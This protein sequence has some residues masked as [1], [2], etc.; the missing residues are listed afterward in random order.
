MKIDEIVKGLNEIL[1][2]FAICC[3]S[4]DKEQREKVERMAKSISNAIKALEECEG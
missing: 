1:I 3:Y 4:E 2:Y